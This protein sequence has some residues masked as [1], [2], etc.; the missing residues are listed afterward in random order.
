[1]FRLFRK[2][3]RLKSVETLSPW[4][5]ISLGSWRPTGD[6]SIYSELEL[7]VEPMLAFLQQQNRKNQTA[8]TTELQF[9]GLVMAKVIERYPNINK[10]VR[11]G[12]LHERTDVDIFFHVALDKQ[13]GEDL[14]GFVVRQASLKTLAEFSVDFNT[15][16]KH[17]TRSND[18]E[19]KQV[20]TL[21]RYVPG[22]LSKWL[23]DASSFLLYSLNIYTP[24]VGSPQDS[25][26]SIQITSIGSLGIDSAFVPIAPYTRIPMVISQGKIAKRP[27]VI[28]DEVVAVNTM[29]VCFTVDHRLMEGVHFAKMKTMIEDLFAHP[30]K[31]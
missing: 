28:N 26:G 24:L 23:L 1:V 19:F 17:I 11:F 12:R 29:K 20:K 4:R 10:V 16:L 13:T 27:M 3:V 15:Q 5:T 14:S 6:S 21:F 9:L 7:N 30:E 8:K 22:L 31:L 25:F 18:A 2:N